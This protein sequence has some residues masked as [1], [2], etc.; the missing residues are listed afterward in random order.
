MKA[1]EKNCYLRL[2]FVQCFPHVCTIC[3][4][5]T[6]LTAHLMALFCPPLACPPFHSAGFL[7]FHSSSCNS[8][9]RPLFSPPKLNVLLAVIASSFVQT[10]FLYVPPSSTSSLSPYANIPQ[11]LYACSYSHILVFYRVE[12]APFVVGP[13]P[14][15]LELVISSPPRHPGRETDPHREEGALPL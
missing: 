9:S 15:T 6:R 8:A 11:C 13:Q 14:L 2:V 7:V 5:Q 10:L 3:W 4:R 12:P 1:I